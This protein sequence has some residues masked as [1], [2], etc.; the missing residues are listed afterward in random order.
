MDSGRGEIRT[1]FIGLVLL[2][3][4]DFFEDFFENFCIVGGLELD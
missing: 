4:A 3:I 1:F 2:F